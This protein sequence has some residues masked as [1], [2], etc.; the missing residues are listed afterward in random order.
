MITTCLCVRRLQ[1]APVAPVAPGPEGGLQVPAPG[2][3]CVTVKLLVY[4]ASVGGSLTKLYYML[5]F[6]FLLPAG[7]ETEPAALAAQP[8]QLWTRIHE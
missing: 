1:Q 2:P 8:P 4:A 7:W 6:F 5:L 3:V